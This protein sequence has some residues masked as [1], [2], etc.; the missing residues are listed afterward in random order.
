MKQLTKKEIRSIVKQ[1]D[2]MFWASILMFLGMRISVLL[3]FN[4]TATETGAD[5]EAVHTT[6]EANPLFSAIMR[7]KFTGYVIQ[8]IVI[9][10]IASAVYF[11]FRRK[12]L[13]N[14]YSIDVLQFHVLFTFFFLFFN[15]INDL[16]SLCGRI[17]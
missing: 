6:Y 15:F 7:L 16:I 5:I 17:L 3:L 2:W 14:K 10:A 12:V 8:F 13:F 4:M 1:C 11:I 9:P